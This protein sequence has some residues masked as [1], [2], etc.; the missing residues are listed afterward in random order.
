MIPVQF[1]EYNR[2]TNYPTWDIFTQ[3]TSYPETAQRFEALAQGNE[4][5]QRAVQATIDGWTA[6]GRGDQDAARG[7]VADWFMDAVRLVDWAYV[8]GELAGSNVKTE[9]HE[10]T[11]ATLQFVRAYPSHE[12]LLKGD[13]SIYSA[14]MNWVESQLLTWV[15]S[16][17]A[18]KYQTPLTSFAKKILEVYLAVVDWE[19]LVAAFTEE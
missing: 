19:K 3:I 17:Q 9:P 6:G 11:V 13:T 2:W 16:A 10:L 14:L 5:M 7:I 4:E 18:R 15:S 12:D 8:H 1:D